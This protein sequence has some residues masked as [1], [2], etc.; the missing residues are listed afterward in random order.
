MDYSV[1]VGYNAYTASGTISYDGYATA[2]GPNASASGVSSAA[3]GR[4]ASASAGGAVSIGSESSATGDSSVA[5][6]VSALASYAG[7]VA[8]G[9][10]TIASFGSTVAVGDTAGAIAGGA[11]AVGADSLAG[12]Q[13]ST[14]VGCFSGTDTA[15]TGWTCLG[16][17]AT[18][19]TANNQIQIGASGSTTYAYGAVQNRSDA[20]D[21]ADIRDTELGLDFINALRP[22]QF[23]W[24]M[25]EDYRTDRSQPLA[26]V[27]RDGSKK[28]SRFHNG[29]IAQEVAGVCDALGVDFAG[30]QHHEV[31]GGDDVYS[32]G[33]EELIA[34]LIKAVQQLSA[35]VA[36]LEGR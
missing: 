27:T 32:I 25:R 4:S 23:K 16:Y 10:S 34:P 6:G 22:V 14:S 21:K 17:Q 20:R 15:Y 5:V 3:Y 19:I 26:E 33:Y 2:V 18:V 12:D 31:G 24:D 8:V 28:R 13:N 7:A 29:L 11:T 36:E 1:A 35:R 9:V 30:L